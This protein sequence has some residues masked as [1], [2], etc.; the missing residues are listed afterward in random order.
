MWFRGQPRTHISKGHLKRGLEGMGT[1]WQESTPRLASFF[2]PRAC[3]FPR[4]GAAWQAVK[5]LGS[6]QGSPLLGGRV[7]CGWTLEEKREELISEL[8]ECDNPLG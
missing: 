6:A 1:G 7:C 5:L 4:P 3:L 2:S 8:V